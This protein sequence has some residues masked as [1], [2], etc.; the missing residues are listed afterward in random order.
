M[1][2]SSLLVLVDFGLF[3]VL[4]FCVSRL[5]AAGEGVDLRKLMLEVGRVEERSQI[6]SCAQ[7]FR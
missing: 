7:M 2:I 3:G 1:R 4:R 5:Y 6:E